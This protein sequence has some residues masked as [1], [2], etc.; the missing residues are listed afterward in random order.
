[1]DPKG[2]I[3][4]VKPP[5]LGYRHV[6]ALI[7]F[8]S[9]FLVNIQRMSLGVAIVAMVNQTVPDRLA[10]SNSTAIVCPYSN[11]TKSSSV[12][13]VEGDFS[14]NSQQQGLVLGIGFL[15][16][17]F[18]TIP[19][20][21]LIKALQAK[22]VALFGSI[23]SSVV[24]MLCPIASELHV[25]AMI[26]AQFVRGIGQGFLFVSLFVLMANWFPRKER[27]LLSTCV[28]SGYSIGSAVASAVTGY[29]CDVPELGWEGSFYIMGGIGVFHA[30]LVIVLLY[31]TP[32]SHPKIS[33]A[34]LLYLSADEE[35]N[36]SNNVPK[37]PWLKILSSIPFYALLIGLLGQYWC[38]SYFWTVHSTF[39][40]TIQHFPITENGVWSCLPFLM[41]ACGEYSSSSISNWLLMK[42]YVTVNVLRRT[43]NSIGCIGFS[44]AVLG[45]YY[46][47]CNGSMSAVTAAVSMFFTGVATAGAMITCIDMAPRF[48]GS[49]SAFLN[50]AGCWVSFLLPII[51]GLITR[52]KLLTEWHT[53]FFIS[54]S[55]V[56]LSGVIFAIFGSAE[57]QPWNFVEEDV[58]KDINSLELNKERETSPQSTGGLPNN[59]R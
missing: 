32:Q 46:S 36:A 7:G 21:M 9:C 42:K 12:K 53:V 54:I 57:V 28:I 24:T 52:N 41:K 14:W 15:G 55:F 2:K 4:V 11:E 51:V 38:F 47:G 19:A 8:A 23:L 35:K 26:V 33:S 40:G 5:S 1:M 48:A 45:T 44:A 25:N 49:L 17:F 18:A 59:H 6:V 56:M 22:R 43:C 50:G 10:E 16:F 58:K 37:T 30:A 20:S 29:I 3:G 13:K 39:L 34:E 27:G 31:E